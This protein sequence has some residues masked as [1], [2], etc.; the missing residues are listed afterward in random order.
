MTVS[1]FHVRYAFQSES[2]LSSCLNVKELLARN[3][4]NIQSVIDCNGT[5]T[6]SHLV[7]K[8][9]LN[10]L[11]KLAKWLN[12]A[13]ST[14]LCGAFDCMFWSCHVRV[15]ECMARNSLLETGAMYFRYHACL[16][17]GVPWHSGNYRVLIHSKTRTWHNKNIQCKCTVQISTHNTAQLF[18]QFG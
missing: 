16:E 8:R 3:R 18:G 4:C 15:S 12:C 14:Y 5:R 13:V 11:A 6:H 10:H 9:T 17:E 7:R 1:S 2:T